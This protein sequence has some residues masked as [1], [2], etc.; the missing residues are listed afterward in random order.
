M[1]SFVAV[2]D[3]LENILINTIFYSHEYANIRLHFS[4]HFGCKKLY[5]FLPQEVMT[6]KKLKPFL[7]TATLTACANTKADFK[8]D[9]SNAASTEK[10]TRWINI[11]R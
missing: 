4:R 2:P 1:P 6:I 5:R 8:V 3:I 10:S 11:R 7:L 9:G